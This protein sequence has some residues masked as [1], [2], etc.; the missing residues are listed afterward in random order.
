MKYKEI[1]YDDYEDIVD[2]SKSIWDGNDYL[3]NVF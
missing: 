3:P 1:T 2:I